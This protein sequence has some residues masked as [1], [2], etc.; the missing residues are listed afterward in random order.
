MVAGVIGL[1]KAV[2]KYDIDNEKGASFAT[3]ATFWIRS[4][5][6]NES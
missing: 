5:V 4:E 1:L 3:Y 6:Y 2:E